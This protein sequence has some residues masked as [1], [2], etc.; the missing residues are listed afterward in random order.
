M[1]TVDQAQV[2]K[3]V[4]ALLAYEK[5]T[6]SES[7]K[8]DL[9][10][11][12]MDYIILQIGLKK[13]PYKNRAKPYLIPVAK[14]LF[15]GED[16]EICLLTKDPVE[17][18]EELLEE[19]NVTFI[20]K[21]IS[22]TQLRNQYK[23]YEEKRKLSALYDLFLADDRIVPLLPH[24]IGK[25]FFEK[26]K[27]PI[28]VNLR[29]KNL[30]EKLEHVKNCTPLFLSEGP[31]QMIRIAPS[32]FEKEDIVANLMKILE[33]LEKVIP[34]GWKNI[35]ALNIKTSTSMALPIYNSL[36]DKPTEEEEKK[37]QERVAKTKAASKKREAF[38]QRM[39]DR[40]AERRSKKAKTEEEIEESSESDSDAE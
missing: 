6:K 34:N 29:K 17:E 35:Q 31:C 27:I 16:D 8:N 21:C 19:N 33:S 5:K 2:E 26:K 32:L 7:N 10:N 28:P 3:A 22:V 23:E 4:D 13:I 15:D 37:A 9:L 40:K 36:P 12:D 38:A 1:D 14:S 20:N 24:L 11:F 18:Y 39:A 30:K 25:K